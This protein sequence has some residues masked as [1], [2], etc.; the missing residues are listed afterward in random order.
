MKRVFVFL[1]SFLVAQPAFAHTGHP[2]FVET[3]LLHYLT[4]MDHVVVLM[5]MVSALTFAFFTHNKRSS[6]LA[7][8]TALILFGLLLLI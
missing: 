6:H 3:G 5:G 1:V 8:A 2:A 7:G 4:A